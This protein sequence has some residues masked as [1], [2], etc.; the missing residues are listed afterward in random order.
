[1]SDPTP[2]QGSYPTNSNR[3]RV[4]KIAEVKSERPIL[5]PLTESTG[6][7]RKKPL[8]SRLAE[9]F[10][11]EEPQSVAAYIGTEV[12]MPAI[13]NTVVDMVSQ[14]IERLIFGDV[15]G[16]I[17]PGS[18]SPSNRSFTNYNGISKQQTTSGRTMNARERATHDFDDIVLPTRPEVETVINALADMIDNFE[19]ATVADLY[20][21]VNITPAFTDNKWGWDTM[22]GAKAIAV[23]GGGYMFDLPKPIPLD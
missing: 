6:V 12:I 18:S 22:Q 13:K 2:V 9:T 3:A 1:M 15:K 16:R 11:G 23:R 7:K 20:S 4:E 5:K 21:A 10:I 19:T 14:G 17:R 8:G